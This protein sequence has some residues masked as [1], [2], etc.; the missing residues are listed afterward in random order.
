MPPEWTP[1][2]NPRVEQLYSLKIGGNGARRGIRHYH[3][4]Y[5]GHGR[6]ARSFDMEDLFAALE[7]SIKRYVAQWARSR[8]FVNA[9]VV[10]WKGRA[11]LIPGRSQTGKTTLVAELVKHGAVY[12]SDEYAV[13]DGRARVHPYAKPLG[14]RSHG[15]SPQIRT[16]IESLGGIQ[17]VKPSPVG[18][19][20][21]TRFQEGRKWRPRGV[22]GGKAALGLLENVAAS[23]H[24]LEHLLSVLGKSG[25][26]ALM[27]KGVRGEASET[28]L[29]LLER[30]EDFIAAAK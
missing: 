6:L 30:I 21:L 22:S 3:L 25:E 26:R 17:G 7:Q 8:V 19:I 14:I 13:L 1:S 28:A 9:G 23:R 18:M 4:L 20:V 29:S 11:I 10:G 12:Y 16:S 2:S 15:D 24:R 5:E 27:L